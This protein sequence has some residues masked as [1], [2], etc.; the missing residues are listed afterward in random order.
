MIDQVQ[1]YFEKLRYSIEAKRDFCT[2]HILSLIN[3]SDDLFVLLRDSLKEV[4]LMRADEEE[5]AE[6]S[7]E[8]RVAGQ[9][10]KDLKG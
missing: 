9:P 4:D 6:L 3:D 8:T 1:T 2:E 5:V 7:D 10:W